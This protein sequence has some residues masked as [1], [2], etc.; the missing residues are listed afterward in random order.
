MF[1]FLGE[2]VEHDISDLP[3]DRKIKVTSLFKRPRVLLV[4]GLIGEEEIDQLLEYAA[5]KMKHSTVLRKHHEPT[6]EEDA[7]KIRTYSDSRTSTNTFIHNDHHPIARLIAQRCANLTRTPMFLAE[8]MQVIHY[9][10]MQHY[11]AHMDWF[12]SEYALTST[13][14]PWDNRFVTVLL[15]FNNVTDG[16]ET[17]FP[18]SNANWNAV[19]DGYAEKVCDPAYPALRVRPVKGS[20]AI[21]YN[22][23]EEAGRYGL[24]DPYSLHGGCDVKSGEKWA[25]NYWIHNL[26]WH[27]S[28]PPRPSEAELQVIRNKFGSN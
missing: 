1:P 12:G 28:A 16:G 7:E 9:G 27:N 5:P 8:D 14:H 19:N 17:V 13:R 21:F 25:A 6:Q 26:Y 23:R 24:G 3:M 15:Y 2:G 10:K 18:R 11:H 4:E 20:A 22:L